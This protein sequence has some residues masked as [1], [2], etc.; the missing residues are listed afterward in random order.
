MSPRFHIMIE[1]ISIKS[2]LILYIAWAPY[3]VKYAMQSLLSAKLQ[4]CVY[5]YI[6]ENM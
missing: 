2:Q 5:L 1:I 3:G 6:L 4:F